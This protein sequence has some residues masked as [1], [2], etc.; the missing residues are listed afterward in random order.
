MAGRSPFTFLCNRMTHA[1]T[2]IV[3]RFKGGVMFKVEEEP[4]LKKDELPGYKITYSTQRTY[5]D[6]F[7]D[8][9]SRAWVDCWNL[10]TEG[11]NKKPEEPK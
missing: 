1:A 8:G 9:Y 4:D 3:W 2:A 5:E 11:E 10:F 7:A 6:G